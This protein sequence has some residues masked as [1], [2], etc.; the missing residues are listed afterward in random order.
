M[1]FLKSNFVLYRGSNA[2]ISAVKHGLKPIYLE[3]KN[4]PNIDLFSL[5]KKT[6]NYVNK[7]EQLSN[8]MNNKSKLFLNRKKILRFVAENECKMKERNSGV[9]ESMKDEK[10]IC[11]RLSI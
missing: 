10:K 1:I 9:L 8:I 6:V 2:I 11:K 5:Y 3:I 4:E 7:P